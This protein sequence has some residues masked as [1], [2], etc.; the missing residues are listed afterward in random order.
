M[1]R[2]DP[3]PLDREQLIFLDYHAVGMSIHGHPMES[4]RERQKDPMPPSPDIEQEPLREAL[5][6]G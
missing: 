1:S 5:D 4:A 2:H 3:V 6:L